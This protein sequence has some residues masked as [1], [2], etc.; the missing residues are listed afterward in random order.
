MVAA[1]AGAV[2]LAGCAHWM[3]QHPQEEA[4]EA[5]MVR[6]AP[7]TPA[8]MNAAPAKAKPRPNQA[9]PAKAPTPQRSR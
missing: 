4:Q 3:G 6:P 9:A 8:P 7:P 2:A 1:F 5:A